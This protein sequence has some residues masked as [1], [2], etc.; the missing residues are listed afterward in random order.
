MTSTQTNSPV[1]EVAAQAV[2]A[3]SEGFRPALLQRRALRP[4]DVRIRI[5]YAGIC[6]SDLH[7]VGADWGHSSF[8]MVPGHEIS[9]VVSEVGTEAG[10][11][12]VGDPV[13]VG[14]L[15]GS[16]RACTACERGLEQYCEHGVLTY[17]DVDATGERTYG[18]YSQEIVVD[19]RYVIRI[20]D[21]MDLAGAA[22]LMCAGI[23][24][25][26]PLRHWGAGPGTRVGIV[27]LGGLGHVGVKLS[28]ALGAH[29]TVFDLDPSR[30]GDAARL[31]ADVFVRADDPDAFAGRRASFDLLISTVPA[32]L[33]LDDY[34]GMLDLE[35]TLVNLGV[36]AAPLSVAAHSL[37]RGRRS[38]AGSLIGGIAE[39]Q[40]MID[41][42]AANGVLAETEVIAADA[43]DDA[44]ERLARGDVRYRFVIDTATIAIPADVDVPLIALG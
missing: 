29:T 39:T 15:V 42:C 4:A 30:E 7:H 10:R 21:G 23:T 22:P 16:C 41:F 34:L 5:A 35:G 14:C 1:T 20:P 17:N 37:L 28:R 2:M 6:H 12:A 26:S 27:G 36:P 43:I 40:E 18:G 13:G 25:Y 38:L 8:P 19:S 11:F 32:T 9:G 24:L 44:Y 33:P 31:G 3:R